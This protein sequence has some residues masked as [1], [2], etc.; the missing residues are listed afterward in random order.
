MKTAILLLAH[1]TPDAVEQIPEYLRNVTS[2]RALPQAAIDE[3]TH[4]YSLIGKS[5]LTEITLAQARLLAQRIGVPVYVGMRNWKPYIGTAV[6][7]MIDDGVTAAAA[8]C[9]APQNSRTSVGLYRRAVLAEAGRKLTVDFTDAWA[10]HPLLIAAFADRL[11]AKYRALVAELGHPLPVLFTAHS[12]PLRTVQPDAAGN[13]SDPYADQARRTAALVAGELAPDGLRD[14]DGFFAFQSQGISGGPW[15]GPTVEDTF[16][17]IREAG[18]T[19]VLVQPIGFLCDHVEILYDI[20]I[21]FREL[22]T[23]LG[24][25]VARTESLNESSILISALADLAQSAMGRL[26]AGSRIAVS[27]P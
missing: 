8:I 10:D 3:I 16:R 9:L 15:I 19:A 21:A 13:G 22:G 12:V 2:C 25:R 4:R 5:P 17:E 24:L 23:Q 7:Q 20:D 11:R 27:V 18:H 6:Q 1:G 26:A 14:S